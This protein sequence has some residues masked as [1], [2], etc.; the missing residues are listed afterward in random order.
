MEFQILRRLQLKL[1]QLIICK[2]EVGEEIIIFLFQM[3]I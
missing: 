3:N 2:G 1:L